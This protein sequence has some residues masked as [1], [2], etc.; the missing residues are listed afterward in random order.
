MI[1]TTACYVKM[2]GKQLGS[3][4]IGYILGL[5]KGIMEKMETAILFCFCGR[6]GSSIS[7]IGPAAK[8]SVRVRVS[9]SSALE[10]P[11]ACLLV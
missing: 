9:L 2:T 11:G 1:V 5:Y 10:R 8:V 7:W 3:E 6:T 4:H